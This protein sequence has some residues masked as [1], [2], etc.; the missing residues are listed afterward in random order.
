MIG[1]F[2]EFLQLGFVFVF[3]PQ[4]IM[5]KSGVPQGPSDQKVAVVTVDDCDMSVALKFGS[6]LGNYSCSAQGTQSGT[7]K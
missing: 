7:K 3:S 4:P 2:L 1:L 5:G 6:I